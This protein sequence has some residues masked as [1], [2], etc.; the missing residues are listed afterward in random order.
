MKAIA[1][2]YSNEVT[3]NLKAEGKGKLENVTL[4]K[5]KNLSITHE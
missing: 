2:I 1:K 5:Y 3:L 4:I